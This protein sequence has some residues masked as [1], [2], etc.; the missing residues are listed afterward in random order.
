M[1]YEEDGLFFCG[2][3]D[4]AYEER[5]WAERCEEHCRENDACS[6]DITRHSVD[7]PD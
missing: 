3:C 4:M 7:R 5:K 1:V 2:E 6:M